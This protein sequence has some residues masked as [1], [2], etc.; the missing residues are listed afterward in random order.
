ML[1][2]TLELRARAALALAAARPEHRP[3]LLRSAREATDGILAERTP[4]GGALALK[5][6]AMQ[7]VL[8]GR[9]PEALERLLRSE[10]TFEACDMK[11]H[12]MVIRHTRG[13][14]LGDAEL[15][16]SAEAWMKGQGIRAP[17]RFAAMHAPLPWD[18]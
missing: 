12:A 18:S 6:Q 10:I 16:G 8:D 9:K 5:L 3:A 15:L 11:L 7:A 1:L 4:Y 17:G 2:T 13:R 14:L